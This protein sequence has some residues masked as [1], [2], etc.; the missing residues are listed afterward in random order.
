MTTRSTY[1]SERVGEAQPCTTLPSCY[2]E[3]RRA[4]VARNSST[5]S[6]SV[7]DDAH[8]QFDRRQALPA[9]VAGIRIRSERR[10]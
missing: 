5:A 4:R 2:E 10:S 3:T 8:D 9:T 1:R 7:A 6:V